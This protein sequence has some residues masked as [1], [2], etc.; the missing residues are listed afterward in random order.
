MIKRI[1]IVSL[2]HTQCFHNS[3]LLNAC[4][5]FEQHFLTQTERLLKK[6]EKA[7][8]WGGE[9]DKTVQL[10]STLSNNADLHSLMHVERKHFILLSETSLDT[11]MNYRVLLHSKSFNMWPLSILSNFIIFWYTSVSYW[12]IRKPWSASACSS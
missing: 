8:F 11:C 10:H 7:C 6:K 2:K 12:K 4:I 9:F 1:E 3:F 5:S